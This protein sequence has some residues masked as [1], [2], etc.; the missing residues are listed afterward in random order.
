MTDKLTREMVLLTDEEIEDVCEREEAGNDW[1]VASVARAVAL[2]QAR[3]IVDVMEKP[4]PHHPA[5][6]TMTERDGT[7]RPFLRRDCN[8]CWS[9]LKNALE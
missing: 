6:Y 8:Q 5:S 3:K 1:S 4:C 7:S 9:E 2:A